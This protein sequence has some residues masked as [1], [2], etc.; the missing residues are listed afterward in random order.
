M[1]KVIISIIPVIFS[2]C[3]TLPGDISVQES[4]TSGV[5][6]LVAEPAWVKENY[7]SA[8]GFKLGLNKSSNMPKD[9]VYLN[10][11]MPY[12]ENIDSKNGVTINIDGEK[13]YLS[14]PDLL[15][16]HSVDSSAGYVTS[17]STKSFKVSVSLIK[18]MVEGKRVWISVSMGKTYQEAEFSRDEALGAKRSFVKFLSNVNKLY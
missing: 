12:I 3:M 15:T 8:S 2:S 18:R 16:G 1:K 5:K 10:I 17:E 9:D 4:K 6:T 11:V 7:M 14:S 13:L